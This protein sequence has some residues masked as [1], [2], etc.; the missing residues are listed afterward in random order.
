M[1]I[2]A[3]LCAN[4]ALFGVSW[5]GV[6]PAQ[7]Y[8]TKPVRLVVPFPP[9]GSNDIVGR[10]MAQEL[11]ERLGKQVVMDNRGGAGG[12]LGTEIA[13]MPTRTVLRCSSSRSRMRSIH[14]STSYA[15]IPRKPLCPSRCWHGSQSTER[16]RPSLLPIQ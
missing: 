12:V 3:V 10:L 11:T 15:S 14:I 1:K 13:R 2:R 8:P 6:A 16:F 4:I 7:N 9:G 5:S